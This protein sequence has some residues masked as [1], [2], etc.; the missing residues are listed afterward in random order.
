MLF[1]EEIDCKIRFI[2]CRYFLIISLLSQNNHFLLSFNM[3]ICKNKKREL[4]ETEK[5]YYAEAC[6]E[7]TGPISAS[8]PSGNPAAYEEMLQR[9]RTIGDTVS[10]SRLFG[11]TYFVAG[12]FCTDRFVANSVL[13]DSLLI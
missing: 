7:L 3:S 9:W 1:H 6:N 2:S 8:L 4:K 5:Q 10:G 12:R 11:A 13:F